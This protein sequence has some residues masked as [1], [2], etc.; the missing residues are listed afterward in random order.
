MFDYNYSF[1][2]YR[3]RLGCYFNVIILLFGGFVMSE[4]N[5]SHI[6][7][8]Y[9]A[10]GCFWCMEEAFEKLDGVINAISGYTGGD[11]AN[12]TYED[13]SHKDTGHYEAI[14]VIYNSLK[15][16]YR[17]LL[18]HFWINIDPTQADG[19]FCDKGKQYLSA[20]FYSNPSEK[21]LAEE[22]VKVYQ[23]KVNL[24]AVRGDGK[25][26]T[27]FL[28]LGKFYE[29]EDY[30]QSYYKTRPIRYK[31]YKYLCGRSQRLNDLWKNR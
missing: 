24:S 12:P 13:V 15:I 20:V 19:Q 21:K 7:F 5:N 27:P 18:D 23:D 9:F 14:K 17:Q 1:A 30:H 28:P 8:A 11:F 29:A 10:G 16:D 22:T 25:F 31:T 3:R 4:T 2:D 6:K 26:V